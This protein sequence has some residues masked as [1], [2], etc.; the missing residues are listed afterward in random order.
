LRLSWRG[1]VVLARRACAGCYPTRTVRFVVPFPAG[2]GTDVLSRLLA[3]QLTRKWGRTS[4]RRTCPG[5]SGN[6]GALDVWRASAGRPHH[7]ARP[8][9]ADRDQPF[10]FKE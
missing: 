5:A 2:S 7:D 3:D 9:R 6:I 10:L 8:A 1:A 4:S